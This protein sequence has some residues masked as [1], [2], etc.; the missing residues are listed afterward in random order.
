MIT[1]WL[2]GNVSLTIKLAIGLK[3]KGA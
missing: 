2:E 3:Q 1:Y